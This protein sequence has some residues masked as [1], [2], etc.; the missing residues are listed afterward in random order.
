VVEVT[1]QSGARTRHVSGHDT[2]IDE[3]RA[4]GA[5]V[6][7]DL[8]TMTATTASGVCFRLVGL[9]GNSRKAQEVWEQW[10]SEQGVVS[11]RD[12]TNDYMDPDDVST[13]Q[14]VALKDSA[15]AS[16]PK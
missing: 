6:A 4:S 12:V 14:F 9:P 5:I 11:E 2:A 1:T 10:C 13:R 15:L 16:K 3:G 8:Q 7:F